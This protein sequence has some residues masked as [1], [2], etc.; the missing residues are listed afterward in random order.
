MSFMP[1]DYVDK[2]SVSDRY[3]WK[4]IKPGDNRFRIFGEIVNGYEYWTN[5][6]GSILP[7]AQQRV[8]GDRPVRVKTFQDAFTAGA[9][10]E[11]KP[12]AAMKVFNYQTEAIE[13]LQIDKITLLR[14]LEKLIA[15]PDWSDPTRY[16]IVISKTVGKT[17]QD[18]S[19]DVV[20]KMPKELHPDVIR[21]AQE[22]I[23]VHQLFT[24]GNPFDPT[25]AVVG[26]SSQ[27][28][29]IEIPF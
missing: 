1:P 26:G 3:S 8:K 10:M 29:D 28:A 15:D 21:L 5:A 27:S 14:K 23:D 13:V 22:N 20:Q 7:R 25:E 6:E 9:D 12:F 11:A 16:D 19:Y 17:P 24:G 2:P 18:T 4:S